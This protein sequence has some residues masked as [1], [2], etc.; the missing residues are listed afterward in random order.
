MAQTQTRTIT[1]DELLAM[2]GGHG[3]RYELIEGELIVT[4]AA[5]GEHGKIAL[6]FA[7]ELYVYLKDHP[8]GILVAAETGFYTRS[9]DRT[10][11]APDLAFIRSEMIPSEGISKGYLRIAPDLVL[12]VVSPNDRAAG[13]DEKVLE[14]LSFGVKE[15]WVA[16]PTTKRIMIYRQGSDSAVILNAGDQI[17]GGGIL[18]GFER[19]IDLFFG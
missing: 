16:Y 17:D 15:V 1:A 13:V 4:A 8:I 12:E 7:G 5:G 9:D 18:P 11:R 10:V 19:A 6:A 2:P 14:W 3:E